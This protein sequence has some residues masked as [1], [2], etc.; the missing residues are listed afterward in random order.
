[1]NDSVSLSCHNPLVQSKEFSDCWDHVYIYTC[2]VRENHKIRPV[3]IR[4]H[5]SWYENFFQ[6]QVSKPKEIGK[7]K[8]VWINRSLL[9]SLRLCAWHRFHYKDTLR[10]PLPC[11]WHFLLYVARSDLEKDTGHHIGCNS[12]LTIDRKKDKWKSKV[13]ISNKKE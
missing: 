1:M 8:P 3:R 13:F 5:R 7:S 2:H 9:L 11:S 4:L 10:T 6:A 12:F